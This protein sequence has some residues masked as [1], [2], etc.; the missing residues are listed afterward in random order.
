MP[1]RLWKLIAQKYLSTNKRWARGHISTTLSRQGSLYVSP[2][3]AQ[4]FLSRFTNFYTLLTTAAIY[5]AVKNL[6][7][8]WLDIKWVNDLYL[9]IEK[10]AI[11]TLTDHHFCR[12][13]ALSRCYYW[14]WA[15]T[16]YCWFP[17]STGKLEVSSLKKKIAQSLQRVDCRNL[18]FL[19]KQRLMSCFYLYKQSI[20]LGKE[21]SF[22]K[23]Q[24]T[25]KRVTFRIRANCR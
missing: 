22:K 15:S 7:L 1:R 8:D 17:K 12:E 2:P 21:I 11:E 3:Q 20:V 24:I 10:I 9:E 19:Q 23:D 16:F 5:K 4:S 6:S 13:P 14:C 25:E 18:V